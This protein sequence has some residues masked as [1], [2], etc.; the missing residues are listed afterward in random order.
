[1]KHKKGIYIKTA[2]QQKEGEEYVEDAKD[3]RKDDSKISEVWLPNSNTAFRLLMSANLCS[4]LMNNVT[5][6]DETYNYWEPLHHLLYGEGFQTWEYSP[7]YAIRSWAYICL[8]SMLTWAHLGFLNEN[9]LLVFYFIRMIFGLVC[10]LCEIQFYK[11][12]SLRFGNNV[13]RILLALMVLGTGMFISSTAFLPSTFCMF[14]T[15]LFMGLWLQEK[16][17]LAILTVAASAIIGWPFSVALGIPLAV[18]ILIRRRKYWFFTKWCLVAIATMLLPSFLI[19]SFFYGKPVI[20]SL[21]ILTYNVFT[22]HGPDIYGTEPLSYYVINGF[23]NFNVAFLLALS[24]IV[25]VPICEVIIVL[26]HAGYRPPMLLISFSIAPMYI[27]ILIFFTRPHKEE[28]FL[29]PIYPLI[30][31]SSAVTIATLQK[32][33]GF[34]KFHRYLSVQWIAALVLTIYGVISLSRSFALFNAYHGSMELYPK[35]HHIADKADT[36]ETTVRV[37]MGKEW[38]R[39][40]SSFLLPNNFTLELI[41]SEFKGQ[42]PAKFEAP[43]LEGT[44][45]EPRHFND[46]NLEEKSRYVDVETCHFLIDFNHGEESTHEPIYSQQQDNWKILKEVD[47][48][49]SKKSTSS[50]HRAFFVPF[51]FYERN[52]FGKYQLLQSRTNL[53][54]RKPDSNT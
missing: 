2:P 42:L 52:D 38:H 34:F 5:D 49:I 13:A 47:F 30:C 23:L 19:D 31:L 32:L 12:V 24:T 1:M 20:A 45:A 8:H 53:L 18:D 15:F 54:K 11:G 50:L 40:P 6:C 25:I 37:C 46:E 51:Y 33:Y 4:A 27:W 22:E 39:F 3:C 29:F 28:R 10:T 9:K 14:G 26:K 44:R 35:L 17:N 41:R 16:L 43:G 7:V 21:N 48:L 36:S